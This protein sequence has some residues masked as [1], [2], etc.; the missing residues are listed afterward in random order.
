MIDILSSFLTKILI[1]DNF[2]PNSIS[3]IEFEV[4]IK[5]GINQLDMNIERISFLLKAF[6]LKSFL[7]EKLALSPVA[8][9]RNKSSSSACR[10]QE[11]GH[12]IIPKK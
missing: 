3:K 8:W 6:G 4:L 2:V 9:I 5:R 12:W 10:T 1:Y 7:L 11:I